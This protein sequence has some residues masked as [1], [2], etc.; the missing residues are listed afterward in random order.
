MSLAIHEELLAK[1]KRRFPTVHEMLSANGVL[2]LREKKDAGF[3]VHMAKT[4]AGQ[5]L[6][7]Q[8]ATT[9][10]KRV[11]S[12]AD[13]NG[14]GIFEFCGGSHTDEIRKCGLSRSKVRAILSLKAAIENN[15]IVSKSLR[16]APLDEI[17]KEVTKLWGFGDWSADMIAVSFFG[18][19][20]VWAPGDAALQRGLKVL[21]GGD[22]AREVEIIGMVRPYRTYL[23]LH[24]WRGLDSKII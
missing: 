7:K 1:S 8:A 12:A 23:A 22:A 6:S 9:I 5:Q 21:S 3:F 11:L 15:E 14:I 18:H 24:V 10:W 4:V 20:D 16:Q 19:P 2:Y 17:R 13:S